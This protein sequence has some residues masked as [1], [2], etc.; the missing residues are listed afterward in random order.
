MTKPKIKP[1]TEWRLRNEGGGYDCFAFH[2][3][4]AAMVAKTRMAYPN[5]W[6]VI[7]VEIRPGAG[8]ICRAKKGIS[9]DR[10]SGR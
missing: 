4:K 8:R 1:V 6:S 2:R 10:V 7:R 9:R 3:K 5:D